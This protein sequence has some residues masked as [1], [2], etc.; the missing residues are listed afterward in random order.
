MYCKYCGEK[1]EENVQF[2][3]SCGKELNKEKKAISSNQKYLFVG[4]GVAVVIILIIVFTSNK[5]TPVSVTKDFLNAAKNCKTSKILSNSYY[6]L[7]KYDPDDLQDFTEEICEEMAN[8]SYKI[9]TSEIIGNKARVIVRIVYRDGEYEDVDFYLI[10][11]NK[12]WLVA[13]DEF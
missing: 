7:S 11:P 3:A 10:K 8:A 6:S 12:K 9:G 13:I 1:N 2:C 4:I 5:N